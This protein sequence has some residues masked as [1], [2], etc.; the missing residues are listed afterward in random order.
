M[1]DAERATGS[2]QSVRLNRN[3]PILMRG[4]VDIT[5][6]DGTHAR[7]DRFM[8]AICTCGRSGIYPW[9]DTSHRKRRRSR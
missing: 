5:L 3:G 6:P 2:V 9:C 8:V 4:P 7:S 1:T